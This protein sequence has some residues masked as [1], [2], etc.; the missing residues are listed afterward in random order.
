MLINLSN[1]PSDL[2]SRKQINSAVKKFYS[3]LDIP[4]PDINPKFSHKDIKILSEKYY[5]KII[6]ILKKSKDAKN[7]VHI[8]GEMTFSFCLISM[9]LKS[10]VICVASTTKRITKELKNGTKYSKF[11]FVKFRRYSI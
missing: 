2:W 8:M 6:N 4:F 3:V 5:K 9:L 1:H 10:N 7:A 11:N